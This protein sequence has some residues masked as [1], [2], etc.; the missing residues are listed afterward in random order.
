MEPG[1]MSMGA[2]APEVTVQDFTDEVP[3]PP[4]PVPEEPCSQCGEVKPRMH[5]LFFDT[6]EDVIIDECGDM[7]CNDRLVKAEAT[8][9]EKRKLQRRQE[10][11]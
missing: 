4:E 11:Q 8:R 5:R 9:D 6:G 2:Y 1:K 10:L 7:W 3:A